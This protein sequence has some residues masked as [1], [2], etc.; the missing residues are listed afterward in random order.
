MQASDIEALIATS[1]QESQVLEFKRADSLVG[2]K[3]PAELVKDVT[4]MA[5][6]IGGRIIYGV[7]ETRLGSGVRVASA[8]DPITDSKMNR[9]WIAQ[10]VKGQS[11]PPFTAFTVDEVSVGSGRVIV[12]TVEAAMT[13][14]QST[15]DRKYYQRVDAVVEAMVDFQVRDVM[16]RRT[17]PAVLV[18]LNRR[19]EQRDSHLHVYRFEP[20]VRNIG[21]VTIERGYIEIDLPELANPSIQAMLSADNWAT[22]SHQVNGRQHVRFGQRLPDLHPEQ[23][24]T[25]TGVQAAPAIRASVS[26][27]PW[28]QMSNVQAPIYWRVFTTDSRPIEGQFSFDE[29]C[30]F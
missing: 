17:K 11:G 12:V 6:A 21:S 8:L 14:H 29:W 20:S 23:Q 28:D 26:H 4:G 13:A 22:S 1:T 18:D 19:Y 27:G 10:T 7:A 2:G 24:A 16:A 9:E 15:L 30:S 25:I 5:N 3:A